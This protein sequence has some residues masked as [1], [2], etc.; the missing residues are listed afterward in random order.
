MEGLPFFG[1]KVGVYLKAN[2]NIT[3]VM[4]YAIEALNM[5]YCHT[6][7]MASF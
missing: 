2:R 7:N 4:A 6:A 5:V 1:K 3:I